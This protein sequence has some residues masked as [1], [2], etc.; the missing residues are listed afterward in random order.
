MV[1][2]SVKRFDELMHDPEDGFRLTEAALLLALDEYPQLQVG[3]YLQR[4]DAMVEQASTRLGVTPS[5]QE[6]LFELNRVL[7]K[8]EG[9]RGNTDDYYDPRNSYLNEVLDRKLGIP[10]TLSIIYMDVGERLGL[11]LEGVSFPG[12]FLVKCKV[13]DGII[14]ID[15]FFSGAFLTE[16]ELL[17]RIEEVYGGDS[18]AMLYLEDFLATAPKRDILVRML[19]N[20]KGIYLKNHQPDKAVW[21]ID[22]ILRVR[23]DLPNELRDRGM[24]YEEMGHVSAALADYQRYLELGGPTAEDR[25]EIRGRVIALQRSNQHLM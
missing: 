6:A 12:H 8:E 3:S 22:R 11:P 20:L 2:T 9:F 4:L 13:A 14:V 7:F 17:R 24:L 1:D 25:E 21:V 19:R 10:I 16:Q 5:M 15:P 23:P 18:E